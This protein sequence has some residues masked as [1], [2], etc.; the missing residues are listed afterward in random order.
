MAAP[1]DLLCAQKGFLSAQFDTLTLAQIKKM[2]DLISRALRRNI[3]GIDQPS[4]LP[5]IPVQI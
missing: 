5:K 4:A 2:D 3:A 1:P